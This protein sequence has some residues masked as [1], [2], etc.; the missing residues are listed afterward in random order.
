MSDADERMRV[1]FL[2]G[3][4][5]DRSVLEES[6]AEQMLQ[7]IGLD[8]YVGVASAHRD[9]PELTE[10]L[11]QHTDHV[12]AYVCIAGLANALAGK[13][14][15]HINTGRFEP[16][17]I[18]GVALDEHG[19]DPIAYTAPGLPIPLFVGG[20][21]GIEQATLFTAI[22]LGAAD[23][24]V[25][26]NTQAELIRRKEAKP[27]NLP[28]ILDTIA[29]GKTKE[30]LEDVAGDGTRVL[31]RSKDDITAGDGER[32]DELEGKAVIATTTTVNVFRLLNEAGIPTHFLGDVDDV[33]FEARKLKMIPL[34][35]V[36]RRI[37]TG[38]YLKRSPETD[39]GTVFDDIVFE[40]FEKDD[41]NHDPM[42]EFD[43]DG[44]TFKRYVASKP[45]DE[46]LISEEPL[47]GSQLEGLS[48]ATLIEMEVLTRQVFEVLE[49]AW[50]K[51]KVAL[52]DLKIEFGFDATTGKLVV[53]DVIDNDSWRIWPGGDKAQ[54]KDKQVYRDLAGVEDPGAKAKELGKIKNNYQ[55]V[56]TATGRFTEQFSLSQ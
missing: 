24:E 47:E 56:A 38:S 17:P 49:A 16:K 15:A 2:I 26:A 42:V 10:W 22:M 13:T 52:V 7:R 40:V 11:D 53:G 21:R 1:A 48:R 46:G 54:M 34:E 32:R 45:K 29:Q 51:Q 55:W 25:A 19:V 36:T 27:V 39:E 8:T 33:T 37:A 5:S 14:A 28:P 35:L 30:I 44:G 31:I 41:E 20:K 23:P 9:D 18:I 4:E 50:G 12:Q 6:G 3:S 43:F